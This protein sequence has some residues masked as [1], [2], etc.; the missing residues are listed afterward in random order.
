MTE[1]ETFLLFGLLM[2]NFANTTKLGRSCKVALTIASVIYFLLSI[3]NSISNI[4]LILLYLLNL[5]S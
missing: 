4:L 3:Y 1:S 2:L 5:A